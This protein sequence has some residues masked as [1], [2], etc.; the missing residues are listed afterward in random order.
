MFD[1]S[2]KSA[3]PVPYRMTVDQTISILCSCLIRGASEILVFLCFV[4]HLFID[5]GVE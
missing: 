1:F 3:N 4:C 2:S 5:S